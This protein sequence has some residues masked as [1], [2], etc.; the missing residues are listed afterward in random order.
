MF[1]STT[2][3]RIIKTERIIL[4]KNGER[5]AI[6][7]KG[8]CARLL[9]L[10]GAISVLGNKNADLSEAYP[11]FESDTLDFTGELFVGFSKD[12]ESSIENADIRVMYYDSI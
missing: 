6:N 3:P 10:G 7:T 11:L 12:S 1:V 5:K 2:A 9:V 4:S 8:L